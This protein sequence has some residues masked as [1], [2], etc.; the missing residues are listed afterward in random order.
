VKSKEER[1][2]LSFFS[3]DWLRL[4]VAITDEFGTLHFK[5]VKKGKKSFLKSILYSS[6]FKGKYLHAS[7]WI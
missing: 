7:E 2:I 1:I 4:T 5:L 3:R 6:T